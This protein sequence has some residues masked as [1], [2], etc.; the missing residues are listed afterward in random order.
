[1]GVQRFRVAYC[2]NM[3]EKGG[4]RK[5][6]AEVLSRAEPTLSLSS[7]QQE[8]DSQKMRIGSVLSP[9]SLGYDFFG[10]FLCAKEANDSLGFEGRV[11]RVN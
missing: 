11:R 5:E 6:S 3:T 9:Q 7:P 10:T 2:S 1:M 8:A 4:R